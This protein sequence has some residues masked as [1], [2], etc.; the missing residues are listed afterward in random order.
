MGACVWVLFCCKCT[1]EFK[2]LDRKSHWWRGSLR[3]VHMSQGNTPQQTRGALKYLNQLLSC[4]EEINCLY[5]AL[6][7]RLW[8]WLRARLSGY[9]EIL[10]VSGFWVLGFQQA[11][12]RNREQTYG[13]LHQHPIVNLKVPKSVTGHV[14]VGRLCL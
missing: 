2:S 14:K 9:L 7:E 10:A 1:S 5:G 3:P 11:Y 8:V 12:Q 4:H 6:P 13:S